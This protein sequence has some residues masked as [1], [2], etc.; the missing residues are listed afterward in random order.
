MPSGQETSRQQRPGTH[1]A[2]P[3]GVRAAL[4]ERRDGKGKGNR[5]A[6]IADI[7]Q[8]RMDR[9]TDVLKDRVEVIA[10]K[11]RRD[12]PLNGLE[13]STSMKAGNPR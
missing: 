6:D 12:N 8:R 1:P 7:E 10:F 4:D 11:R 5:E 9:Q 3:G 2:G 13:V